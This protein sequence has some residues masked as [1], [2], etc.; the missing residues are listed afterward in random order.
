MTTGRKNKIVGQTGEYLVAAELS[1]RDLIATTFTGNVPHYDII[2]SNE[3]G[4]HIS[5]QVKAI[6]GNTWQ[7]SD[8][9]QFFEVELDSKKQVIGNPKKSPVKDLIFAMVKLN[10]YG[11]DNFYILKWETLRD[12]I[13]ANYKTYLIKQDF[14]RP[15]R[16][17][18]FHSALSENDIL[19]HKDCWDIIENLL[20]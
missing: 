11:S 2:A 8:I 1:R 6:T 10:D 14:I 3:Y 4:F 20:K 17:D 9:R 13:F 19:K 15:K 18:S 7:F 5:V 12:I 16:Y